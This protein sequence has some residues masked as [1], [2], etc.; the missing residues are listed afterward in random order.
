[1]FSPGRRADGAS[2]SRRG[3][4]TPG[5]HISL[6]VTV[7][8]PRAAATRHAALGLAGRQSKQSGRRPRATYAGGVAPLA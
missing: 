6:G 8:S 5:E 4:A 7:C 3:R 2:T 1:M